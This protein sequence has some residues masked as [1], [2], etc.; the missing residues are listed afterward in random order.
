LVGD[1]LKFIK[2]LIPY[3]V[4]I[5]LVVIIR[6][7]IA[8]PVIVSGDSMD[9]T[10]K[11]KEVLLLNKIS[12]R[13]KNIERYDIV[14]I[15]LKRKDFKKELIKRV[16]GLPGETIEYRNNILY[17]DGHETETKYNYE[18][19]DFT[20]QDICNCSVIPEG[21]YLVLGDNRSVSAD[22]RSSKIGL[23]DEK[24][25]LGKVNISIWPIKKVS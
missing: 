17:I 13:F 4:I 2:E 12:Y 22:S 8:T 3:I 15:N 21:K 9:S 14:V 5:I 1:T 18:T 19:A 7:Y 23:I 16:I 11:D 10:L 24:E 6:T 20:L 25:I